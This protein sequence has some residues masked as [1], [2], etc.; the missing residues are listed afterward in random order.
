LYRILADLAEYCQDRK[1]CL[2][3]Y[4]EDLREHVKALNKKASPEDRS[5][6]A[7][8]KTQNHKGGT[9]DEED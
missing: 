5:E 6:E 9:T 8:S 4:I 3:G 2:D 7:E 1:D